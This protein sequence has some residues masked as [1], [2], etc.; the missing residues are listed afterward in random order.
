LELTKV[1][2]VKPPTTQV[3]DKKP[4]APAGSASL[5][6]PEK[7]GQKEDKTDPEKRVGKTEQFVNGVKKLVGL[8]SN[9]DLDVT[10]ES[11]PTDDLE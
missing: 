7:G 2:D 11:V 9:A 10:L 6:N 3:D 1:T 8:G 5:P 4:E